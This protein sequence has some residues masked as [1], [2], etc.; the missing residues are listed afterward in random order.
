M[1]PRKHI[2]LIGP[3]R[4]GK[5]T[6]ANLIKEKYDYNILKLDELV[7]AFGTT[8]PE[9]NIKQDGDETEV[10]KRFTKFL[11]NLLKAYNN[12]YDMKKNNSHI[13]EG[14]YIDLDILLKEFKKEDLI[15][16]GLHY[17]KRTEE[18]FL[19]CLKKYDTEADWTYEYSEEEQKDNIKFFLKRN[20]EFINMYEKYNIK[21]Y[22]VSKNRDE[23]FKKILNDL[24]N[25]I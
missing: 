12:E 18:D 9:L 10:A 13:I 17:S 25:L 1:Y 11:I 6:L 7:N 24:N 15:I 2:I 8:F 5:S 23:V 21:N 16:I 3:S 4:V 14:V 20:K 19:E 22:D